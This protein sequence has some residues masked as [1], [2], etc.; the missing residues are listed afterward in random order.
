MEKSLILVLPVLGMALIGYL[1]VRFGWLSQAVADGVSR[2]AVAVAVPVV[3]FQ[4]MAN[5]KLPKDLTNIWELLGSYY[6]GALLVFILAMATARFAFH[7]AASEQGAYG[8]YATNSNVVLLG[9]PAVILVLG[10]KWTTLMILVGTHGLVMAMLATIVIGFSRGQTGNLP[11]NLWKD[12]ATQAKQPILIALVAGL[13][14]N[15]FNVSLPGPAN[16]IIA[17][18][19]DAGVPCALFAAGGTLARFSISGI[20][21]QN[22]AI[23]ALKLAAFPVIVW[24]LAKQVMSIPTSWAWIAVMLATMPIAFDVQSRGRGGEAD[25]STVA[26]SNVLGAVSL[27][28]LTYIIVT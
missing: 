17:L 28:A 14:V 3:V 4:T 27:T 20:T 5:S 16:Q 21:Q 2:F 24:V 26:L 15:Q 10:S 19:A 8:A 12:V 1:V 9:L 6:G 22:A 23:C 11:Q 25:S 18:F 13:L 7:G